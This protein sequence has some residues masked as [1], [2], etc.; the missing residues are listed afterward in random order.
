ML[1]KNPLFNRHRRGLETCPQA[2]LSQS[3][4]SATT[5]F[6]SLHHKKEVNNP[7]EEYDSAPGRK[8]TPHFG[9]FFHNFR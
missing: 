3:V 8:Y 4:H 5:L 2:N 7:K 9:S 1:D 6:T